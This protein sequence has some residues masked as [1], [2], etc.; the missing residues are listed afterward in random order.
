MQRTVPDSLRLCLHSLLDFYS[1]STYL[2]Q[3]YR[4]CYSSL[5]LIWCRRV[6][7]LVSDYSSFRVYVSEASS[8]PAI[9]LCWRVSMELF[10]WWICCC[11]SIRVCVTKVVVSKQ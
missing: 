8:C 7:W 2:Y 4:N 5:N 9:E 3:H 10:L 6:Q 11:S 1:S